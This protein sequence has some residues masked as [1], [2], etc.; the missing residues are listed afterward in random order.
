LHF[1]YVLLKQAEKQSKYSDDGFT[2]KAQE[3]TL[4][5]PYNTINR[6]WINR[7]ESGNSNITNYLDEYKIT[8]ELDVAIIYDEN[9]K[10]IT[11]KSLCLFFGLADKLEN[12]SGNS[13]KE[14]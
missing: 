5:I 9:E 4:D 10:S 13:K 3:S 1:L 8:I 11:F 7:D 6:I 12:Y 2:I 14:R